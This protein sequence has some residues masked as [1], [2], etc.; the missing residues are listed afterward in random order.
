MTYNSG[1]ARKI[2]SG[3]RTEFF[4]SWSCNCGEG[5]IID[6]KSLPTK[7]CLHKDCDPSLIRNTSVF[8]L[9][10][11]ISWFEINIQKLKISWSENIGFTRLKIFHYYM[12]SQKNS[13]IMSKLRWSNRNCQLLFGNSILNFVFGCWQCSKFVKISKFFL[14]FC[15]IFRTEN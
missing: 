9:R 8:L 4:R 7:T 2:Q 14:F 12:L 13:E 11:E 6:D 15:F 1:I 3:K 5:L 10:S